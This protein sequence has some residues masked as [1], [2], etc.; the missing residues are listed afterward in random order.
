[1]GGVIHRAVIGEEVEV[2]LVKRL[3]GATT[4]GEVADDSR[5]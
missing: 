5:R 2:D 4:L 1:M 3:V